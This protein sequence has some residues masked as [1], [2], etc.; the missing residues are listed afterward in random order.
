MTNRRHFLG[1][2]A[3]LALTFSEDRWYQLRERFLSVRTLRFLESLCTFFPR[4]QSRIRL[5]QAR[6][7]PYWRK[8]M[9]TIMD[10]KHIAFLARMS[11]VTARKSGLPIHSLDVHWDVVRLFSEKESI[12]ALRMYLAGETGIRHSEVMVPLQETIEVWR[13]GYGEKDARNAYG[14]QVFPSLEA[15]LVQAEKFLQLYNRGER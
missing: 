14:A 5:L 7:S 2:R 9:R 8:A 3:S 6:Q 4:V 10:S 13:A 1:E 12:L 15:Y 11:E